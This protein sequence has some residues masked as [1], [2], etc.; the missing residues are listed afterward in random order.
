MSPLQ[1]GA[2]TGGVAAGVDDTII[3]DRG[4]PILPLTD[5]NRGRATHF[6]CPPA[7]HLQFIDGHR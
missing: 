2:V 4:A 5:E 7:G 3:S 1:K 6:N